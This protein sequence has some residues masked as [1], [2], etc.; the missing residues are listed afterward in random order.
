MYRNRVAFLTLLSAT[1]AL[2]AVPALAATPYA[3]TA[4]N[5]TMPAND[6][7]TTSGGVTSFHLGS[8]Q[9]TVMGVPTAGTL[10]INCQYA[11]P[12][13]SAKIPQECAILFPGEISVQPGEP[14]ITGTVYFVPYGQGPIPSLAQLRSLPRPANHLPATTLALAGALMLGFGFRRRTRRA[15]FLSVFAIGTLVAA[16]AIAACGGT[17]TTGMTP[18]TYPYTIS[19]AFTGTDTNTIQTAS[20]TVTLT[21]Q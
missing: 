8:S 2:P 13:T 4:T 15:L 6:P 17:I 7:P 3:I 19:A 11:G 21:V 1:W 16:T 5:L 10:T 20:T 18:G 14:T 9:F 12:V